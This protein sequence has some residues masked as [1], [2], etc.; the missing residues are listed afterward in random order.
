MLQIYDIYLRHSSVTSSTRE[1]TQ[2][3]RSKQRKLSTGLSTGAQAVRQVRKHTHQ[4]EDHSV[5]VGL[6][7]PS[8]FVGVSP[9]TPQH[10][11][12]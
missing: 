8:V 3:V 11:R 4:S 1:A 5:R 7:P 2:N 6:P 10:L 9:A 12:G